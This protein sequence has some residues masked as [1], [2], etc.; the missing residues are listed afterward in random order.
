MVISSIESLDESCEYHVVA[1]LREAIPQS[2]RRLLRYRSQRHANGV[3]GVPQ[4]D[5]IPQ[6]DDVPH[7]VDVDKPRSTV[8]G[9]W[10]GL[11]GVVVREDVLRAIFITLEKRNTK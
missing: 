3:A 2:T 10:S 4:G 7:G 9:E 1:S 6:G 8:Y 11:T 5:D